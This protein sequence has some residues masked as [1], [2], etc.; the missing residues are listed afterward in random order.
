VRRPPG[1]G[2]LDGRPCSA[3]ALRSVE[4]VIA[5]GVRWLASTPLSNTLAGRSWI[6]PLLQ[7]IHIVCVAFVFAST[8]FFNLRVLGVFSTQQPF[9]AI[10]KRFLP[11]M[12]WTLPF[13]LTTGL[14]LIIAEPER[15]LQS[16]TFRLK[17]L[18]LIGVMVLTLMLQWPLRGNSAFW[19][20][21]ASKRRLGK[22]IAIISLAVWVSIVVAG[23]MIAYTQT[24]T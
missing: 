5:S 8:S 11:W 9:V 16:G 24:D 22:F 7:S 13:L 2:A 10:A 3:Q 12:W 21:T 15:E 20:E 1:S 19:D 23:R 4:N 14:V 17:M 18:L 6:I